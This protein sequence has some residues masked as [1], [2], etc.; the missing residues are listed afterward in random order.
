MEN[1]MEDSKIINLFWARNQEAITCLS[2]KYGKYCDTIAFSILHNMQDS[3]ECVN[4][5]Y[6]NTW[7]SIPPQEPK[8]LKAYLGKL[9]RNTSLNYLK[10]KQ[11]QKRGKG[12]IDLMLSELED[13]IA[14]KNDVES[15]VEE[16]ELVR[17]IQ[18]FLDGLS[19]YKRNIFISRYWFAMSNKEVAKK[20]QL[21]ENQVSTILFRIRN[22]LKI[23][24]TKEDFMV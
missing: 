1:K 9:T 13:C 18:L 14:S 2:K 22:D 7:N 6:L 5:A 19:L 4:D 24:L 20:Y 11:T 3:Q 15:I 8:C 16:H 17:V 10:N 23:F 21:S 12:Q